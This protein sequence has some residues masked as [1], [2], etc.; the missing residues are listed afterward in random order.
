MYMKLFAAVALVSCFLPACGNPCE[1]LQLVC[2]K[3]KDANHKASCEASVD[4]DNQ[5]LC[6]QDIEN[7]NAIC[8]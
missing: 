3:C 2:D 7:F 1:D 5:P 6:Q 4:R 8:K